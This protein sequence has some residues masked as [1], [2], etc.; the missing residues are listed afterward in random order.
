VIIDIKPVDESH[1][2]QIIDINFVFREDCDM[3]QVD[4]NSNDFLEELN[5]HDSLFSGGIPDNQFSLT[6][7]HCCPLSF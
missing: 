1:P 4:L 6:S 3:L 5:N 2:T 7:S